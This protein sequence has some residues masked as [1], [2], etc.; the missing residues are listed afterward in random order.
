MNNSSLRISEKPKRVVVLDDDPQVLRMLARG[1]TGNNVEVVACQELEAAE[2]MLHHTQVDTLVTDLSVSELG[3]FEGFR[4]VR[5]TTTHFPQVNIIVVTGASGEEVIEL[6]RRLG[7]RTI[8]QK[9]VSIDTLRKHVFGHGDNGFS[10]YEQFAEFGPLIQHIQSGKISSVIQPI[11][12]I[13]RKNGKPEPF[14]V[15]CLARGPEKSLLANPQ[16]LFAYADKKDVLFQVDVECIKAG[17]KEAEGLPPSM[18]V[19][20]NVQ[21]RSMSHP[22][23]SGRLSGMINDA[24]ISTNNIVLELTEQ[25]TILNPAAFRMTLDRLRELNL[26]IALDDFG[27]GMANLKLLHELKPDYLKISGHFCRNIDTDTVRQNLVRSIQ[28]MASSQDIPTIVEQVEMSSELTV[29][30]ELGVSYAQGY[31]FGRPA[32]R[33]NYLSK[34]IF[35]ALGSTI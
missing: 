5:H 17:L 34:G 29:L 3:G 13:D 21:P 11:M 6:G 30:Q 18:K 9:P 7:A 31:L 20:I 12:R 26:K 15:E 25:H 10:N 16:L 35:G 22:D 28:Q 14:A 32:P 33:N 24:N 1:L 27:E 19:F 23:F 8:L 4:L 2:T